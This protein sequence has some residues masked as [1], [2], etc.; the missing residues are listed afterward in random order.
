MM[1]RLFWIGFL[2]F[3]V[4]GG[5]VLVGASATAKDVQG[6]KGGIAAIDDG[7]V[8][9]AGAKIEK[10]AGGFRFTEGPAADKLGN[11]YFTDIPNER[12]HLWSVKGEL[13][14]YREKTGRANGLIFDRKGNLLVCEGGNRRVVAISPKGKV[15]VLAERYK[16]K[17]FNSPN[18]LWID[19]QGGIYFSDPR[20]GKREGMELE[21]ECVYYIRPGSKG[22]VR[23]IDDMVRPNGLVGTA[24]GKQLYVTDAGGKKTYVYSIGDD[25]RLTD[26][27]LFVEQGS[28]GMTLDEKGNVY[29]TGEGVVVYDSKGE[30]IERIEVPE[31]PSNV[32]FGGKDEH[33]LFITA[34]S[35]FYAIRM[36]VKG[37][38]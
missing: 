29:L 28:D 8:V 4:C 38:F 10:L 2:V 22:I 18:D 36:R 1:L 6:G 12:I 35:G 5:F 3:G 15:T 7:S 20:Y 30:L 19:L 17:R 25:G 31:R 16:G 11:V 34:R 37:A 21:K 33:T 26:K 23:V 13:S 32:C 9:A 24:N 14:T 27:K